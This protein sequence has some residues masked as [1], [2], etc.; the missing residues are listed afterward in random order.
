[1]ADAERA[2]K[3]DQA[4]AREDAAAAARLEAASAA[5]QDTRKR[6]GL[7]YQDKYAV[8]NLLVRGMSWEEAKLLGAPGVQ[9]SALEGHKDE[10]LGRAKVL[11]DQRQINESLARQNEQAAKVLKAAAEHARQ[12]PMRAGLDKGE[13]R[14]IGAFL[15]DGRRWEQ[16]V[17]LGLDGRVDP[18]VL[19]AWRPTLEAAAALWTNEVPWEIALK[20]A[21]EKKA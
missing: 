10:L 5:V 15:K 12:G 1:M 17:Q 16:A 4:R 7:D 21:I 6:T 9:D 20:R 8:V 18:K 19:E 14:R 2:A 3:D 13:Q 11:I